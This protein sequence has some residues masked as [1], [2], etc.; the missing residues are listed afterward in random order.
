[1]TSPPTATEPNSN[2]T[3][4]FYPQAN[5]RNRLWALWYFCPL[6]A[7][8]TLFGHLVLGFEQAW[9]TP[10]V[11]VSVGLAA[12]L[13]LE[14]MDA[15][16]KHRPP[17]WTQ[18]WGEFWGML[19]PAIIPSLACAMLLYPNQRLLPVVFAVV[20]SIASKPLL[21]IPVGGGRTQHLF[22]PS[23]VAISSTL[24][25]FP[26]VGFA[27]P[28]HLTE[29]LTG[30]WNW[31]VPS[32]ILGTGIIV[33][34][35]FTGRLAL[36]AAWIGGFIAQGL[37]RSWWYG[38]P[39]VAP[40]VP[41]SSAAF[42]LFTLY[43]IPDP[44]TTPKSIAGQLAFG[45]GNAA[46]YGLLQVLHIVFGLFLALTITSGLRGMVILLQQWATASAAAPRAAAPAPTL[47]TQPAT[48]PT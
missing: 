20:L 34:A 40:L 22:N 26:D 11:A 29:N 27:P 14:W 38:T 3:I 4:Q 33:H 1:M 45:A 21:R 47:E 8:W 35:L 16:G 19:P 42:I 10:L 24:L 32:L 17:R 46:V 41:M 30:Q 18:S 23:N 15:W 2:V 5:P 6:I 39:W 43:M 36:C 31:I 13:G 48:V 25:L 37:L 28:Y 12:Q 44:A 9:L 7:L